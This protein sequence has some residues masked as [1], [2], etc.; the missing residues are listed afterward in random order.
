MIVFIDTS[1]LLAGCASCKGLSRLLL[2]RAQP[3]GWHLCTAS[4]CAAEVERHLHRFAK[5]E[6][7]WHQQVRPILH[8]LPSLFI[9]NRPLIFDATKDRPV[10]ISAIG[11]QADYL[12]TSDT[13]D[14]A[15]VLNTAVYGVR[16]RT[17]RTFLIELGIVAER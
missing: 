3:E 10:I 15:H 8:I 9:L 4:Y 17:P 13:T 11:G 12:V 14:F 2:E 1:T 7:V 5:A 6:S 16:V